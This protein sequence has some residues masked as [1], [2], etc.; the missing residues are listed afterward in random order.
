MV[1]SG[2]GFIFLRASLMDPPKTPVGGKHGMS[3][4][5]SR[6]EEVSS[7]TPGGFL[8]GGCRFHNL[9][10]AGWLPEPALVLYFWAMG[11]WRICER[12]GC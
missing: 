12:T 7:L 5:F 8:G 1:S 6:V 4:G 10:Q 3:P 2:L 9:P 11:D